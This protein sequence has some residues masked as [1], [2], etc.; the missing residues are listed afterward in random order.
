MAMQFNLS[1]ACISDFVKAHQDEEEENILF[2]YGV[3]FRVVIY[4]C[5]F[6]VV[7]RAVIGLTVKNRLT[8]HQCP[9]VF[10][11]NNIKILDYSTDWSVVG[12]IGQAD[13]GIIELPLLDHMADYFKWSVANFELKYVIKI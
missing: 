11:A 3:V 1:Q 10:I 12:A 13:S 2:S 8:I 9:L 4:R 5:V 6:A 7:G